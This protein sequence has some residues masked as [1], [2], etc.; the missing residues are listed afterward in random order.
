ML[1]LHFHFHSIFFFFASSPLYPYLQQFNFTLQFT[2]FWTVV[3]CVISLIFNIVWDKKHL[4]YINVIYKQDMKGIWISI[5]Y[6]ILVLIDNEILIRYNQSVNVFEIEM[7]HPRKEI[8]KKK[9]V[10]KWVLELFSPKT[11]LLLFHHPL[12]H[13]N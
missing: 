12:N 13:L 3:F 6:L 2:E 1:Y 11:L 4:K 8:W 9:K 7:R 5:K 10:L